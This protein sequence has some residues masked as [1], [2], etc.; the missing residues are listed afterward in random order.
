[1]TQE[2]EV[3]PLPPVARFVGSDAVARRIVQAIRFG[4][5]DA[6][7][8]PED[9]AAVGLNTVMP[10]LVDWTMRTFM[11]R[12][13]AIDSGDIEVPRQRLGRATAADAEPS[14]QS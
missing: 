8:S 1:M 10:Q 4:L 5:R 7:I 14:E 13:A 6:Y 12:P 11:G 9:I 3:P 2:L